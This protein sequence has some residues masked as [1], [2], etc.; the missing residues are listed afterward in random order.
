MPKKS[1]ATKSKWIQ[2]PLFDVPKSSGAT[3]ASFAP[4]R[5]EI[6]RMLLGSKLGLKHTVYP[7]DCGKPAVLV[8]RRWV[9]ELRVSAEMTEPE[10]LISCRVN[11]FEKDTDDVIREAKLRLKAALEKQSILEGPHGRA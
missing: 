6:Y 1:T 4:V 5:V 10:V 8:G 7:C 2:D 9:H 3:V 11:I